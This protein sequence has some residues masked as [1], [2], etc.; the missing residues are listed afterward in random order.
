[1]AISL[2]V[3]HHSIQMGMLYPQGLGYPPV[4][5]ITHWVLTALE[6]LGVFAVP[7]FLFISG[8]FVAW[9]A[10]G[11]P[12][13]TSWSAVWATLNRILWP[14]VIWSLVFYGVVYLVRGEEISVLDA[15]RKLAIGYPF[16][17]I[18]LLV[19]YYLLSPVL[20]RITGRWGLIL[21]VVI[22]ILQLGLLNLVFPGVLGFE[23]PG[24]VRA[25]VPRS[26]NGVLADWAIYFPLGVFCSLNAKMVVAWVKKLRW[27]LFGATFVLYA[28]HILSVHS[29]LRF[30]LGAYLAPV[31]CV[32]LTLVIERNAIPQV[33]TFEQFGK[34]SYGVYLMHLSVLWI[35]VVVL[36]AVV[37]SLFGVQILLQPILFLATLGGP[38]AFMKVAASL[39]TRKAY[40]YV[41]G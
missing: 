29:V 28:L 6:G 2:V 1:L 32:L 31:P 14:Y 23:F 4:E 8:S 36:A 13:R 9:A 30:P 35:T 41:F 12:P 26:Y 40:R 24:W 15:F 33:R 10:R 5:G 17:F 22:G 38:L 19:F 37:P 25:V 18:P 34:R 39:P 3:L 11:D 21:L 27:V 20:V 7:T 16:H